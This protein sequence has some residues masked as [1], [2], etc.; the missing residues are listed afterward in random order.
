MSWLIILIALATGAAN[1]VQAGMNSEL[2]KQSGAPLWAGVYVYLSGLLCLL[3]VQLF[4][5]EHFPPADRTSQAQWWAWVG[6]PVSIAATMAGVTLAQRL[7]SGIFTGISI[8]AATV[9]SVALDHWGL[10][11]FKQHT[12]SP[13]RLAGCALLVAGIWLVAKF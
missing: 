5:R 1:P 8:T 12:A 13:A 7:G 10:V 6:G 2:N 11:G 4:L 9:A 3:L